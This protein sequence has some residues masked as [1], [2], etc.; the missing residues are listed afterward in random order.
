MHFYQGKQLADQ[1]EETWSAATNQKIGTF[2]SANGDNQN[3]CI[4]LPLSQENVLLEINSRLNSPL[5]GRLLKTG[6]NTEIAL[7]DNTGKE[8]GK[9][10]YHL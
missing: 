3:E 10:S 9:L 6:G 2:K 7:F 8:K 4:K 5:R 1:T